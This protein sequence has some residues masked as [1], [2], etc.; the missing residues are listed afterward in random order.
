MILLVSIFKDI[1]NTGWKNRVRIFKV[2]GHSR[3][4]WNQNWLYCHLLLLSQNQN[5][6]GS[7]TSHAI[8]SRSTKLL[9]PF[10]VQPILAKIIP[11]ILVLNARSI[12]REDAIPAFYAELT[13]N[14]CDI[15]IIFI[16]YCLINLPRKAG[17][18]TTE[19][20]VPYKVYHPLNPTHA[21]YI[22]TN[23]TNLSRW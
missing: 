15:F 7:S 19:H 16:Y 2:S 13:D 1:D 17:D 10:A 18:N 20:W 12:P 22:K 3:T 14:N 8:R 11:K 5:I 4:T 9:R 21:T 23:Y 6:R